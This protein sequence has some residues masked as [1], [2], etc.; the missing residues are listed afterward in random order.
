MG[1]VKVR[2]TW[3]STSKDG[4][5]CNF[6]MWKWSVWFIY[7]NSNFLMV[8]ATGK[9]MKYQCHYYDNNISRHAYSK[10]HLPMEWHTFALRRSCSSLTVIAVLWLTSHFQTLCSPWEP[11]VQIV[12]VQYIGIILGKRSQHKLSPHVWKANGELMLH[13]LQHTVGCVI[14]RSWIFHFR[15][16]STLVPQILLYCLTS[17]HKGIAVGIMLISCL[18]AFICV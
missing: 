16:G 13:Y 14:S 17:K 12:G 4:A 1:L 6:L 7:L 11:L 5:A 15:F 9:W 18:D 8:S 2:P 3:K 10:K